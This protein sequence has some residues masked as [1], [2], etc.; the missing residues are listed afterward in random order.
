VSG[1]RAGIVAIVLAAC[2]T[3]PADSPHAPASAGPQVWSYEVDP[4]GEDLEVV[5]TFPEGTL[6]TFSLE[7]GATPF[8]SDVEV[9]S[10]GAWRAKGAHG[11]VWTL[12]GCPIGCEVRYRFRLADAARTINDLD[13]AVL[14]EG[15]VEAPPST[16]LL[17][18]TDVTA[19]TS[20]RFHVRG[21]GGAR[22]ASGVPP[23]AGAADT[24]GAGAID[25]DTAPYSV[26]GDFRLRALSRHDSVIEV[27]T[28]RGH[29][30]LDDAAMD[31]WIDLSARAVEAYYGHFPVRHLLLVVAPMR[32]GHGEKV[33]GR[34][35]ASGGS[36]IFLAVSPEMTEGEIPKDW[37]LTH[38]LTHLALPTLRREYHWL[39]EGSATYVEP[40]AR[41]QIGGIPPEEAWR[42]MVE[43]LP[44]GE[45]EAGDQGLD[46]THT[47][48]RTYW[49]GAMFCLAAD[50]EIRKRTSGK[51]SFEDALRGI[52]AAGGNGEA[53][54]SIEEVIR[55]GDKAVGVPVLAELHALWGTAPVK[56]DLG[57]MWAELGVRVN[58]SS[59]AFDDTAPAAGIR[60]A[61]TRPE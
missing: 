40:I 16:W 52:L 29:L 37:V 50:V 20:F 13:T 2:A 6:Q 17:R 8:V 7:E 55:E 43:G 30:G 3:K 33:E 11:G 54:W 31:R 5:G 18:P 45:P 59:V 51:R 56:V 25:L 34:T 22:F 47:W 21:A 14:F 12:D 35:L 24:Y 57:K 41:A 19:P 36:S 44:N 1:A 60:R 26:F 38:E 39:E 28:L 15:G 49:G 4:T 42:G 48:G 10:G 61:I 58:G 23:V 53:R 46:R 27:A 32:F 9:K